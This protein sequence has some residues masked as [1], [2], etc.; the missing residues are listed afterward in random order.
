MSKR[1]EILQAWYRERIRPFLEEHASQRVEEF[2]R[3]MMRIEAQDRRATE[4]LA[5]CFLGDSGIGK[6]TLINALVAGDQIVLPAG[7]VGPLTALAMEVRHGA[8]PQFEAEYHKAQAL[9]QGAIFGLER[10][11]ERQLKEETG[12]EVVAV[13]EPPG[14]MPADEPL[15]PADVEQ[16]RDKLESLRKQ[17][18]LLVKGDQNVHAELPYLLDA[19]REACGMKRVWN[20]ESAEGDHA[21]LRRLKAALAM[22]KDGRTHRCALQEDPTGFYGDL[23]DH[24]SGFLAPVIKSLRVQWPSALLENGVVLVDLPGVGVA[25][26]VY[27]EV[28]R[29]WIYKRAKAVVLVV[30]RAGLTVGATD[31]LRTSDFLTRLLFHRDDPTLDPVVLAVAVTHL[32]DVADTAYADERNRAAP[33]AKVRSKAE[34]LVQQFERARVLIQEQLR[35]QLAEVWGSGEDSL[36]ESKRHLIDELSRSA[37]VF[38]VS[39]PQY[40]RLRREDD[41]DRA[42]VKTEEQTGVPGMQASLQGVVAARRGEA[43]GKREEE[44]EGTLRQLETTAQL[45]AE[46]WAGDGHTQEELQRLTD[47]LEEVVAPLREEFRIRQGQYRGF[48]RETMPEKIKGLVGEAKASARKDIG[49]YLAGLRTA[50]WSTLRAAVRKEGAFAGARYVNLPEDFTRAFVEPVAEVWGR[51]IIQDIRKRTREFAGDCE[52]LVLQVAEWCRGQGARVTPRL[53]DAQIEAL[54]ADMKQID[55][56]GRDVINGLREQVKNEL[57]KEVHKPIRR[58]CQDF[59]KKGDDIGAGV[60][61][62]M[63]ELFEDL[64]DKASDRASAVAQDL[65]LN[66]FRAVAEELRAVLRALDDP[67]KNATDSILQAHRK[68]VERE[69]AKLRERVLAAVADVQTSLREA[70]AALA[71]D[72]VA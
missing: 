15:L 20:A 12:V 34:H 41:D 71:A 16:P 6:S 45:L 48:L 2:D 51:F 9:Q 66:H 21:R 23:R 30:G 69:D 32:D 10:G 43:E 13:Q 58:A 62:R 60:M 28:T 67:L 64:G 29:E 65:L 33:G 39:A 25:G 42:W 59:V 8:V 22:A 47:D 5:I 1:L 24:A 53:L 57:S 52:V 19:L 63:L 26:D 50:H 36:R 27:K 3:A 54:H 4:E 56:A 44:I 55:L 37:L 17:A 11:Y 61:R 18:Q 38:P 49:R 68:R 7:G 31:L 35:Q 70:R 72:R 46:Q 14:E 40:Q